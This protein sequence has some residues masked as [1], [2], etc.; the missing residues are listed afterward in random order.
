FMT[1]LAGWAA[2]LGRLSG[3]SDLVIGTP[4]ANRNRPEVQPMI[5]FFVNTLALRV[6]LHDNPTV[7]QLL[8][9][10]KARA[11][12][13]QAH[14]DL[15][16][17]QVVEIAKPPRS[18]AHAPLFQVVFNWQSA[19]DAGL[20]LPGL[21]A[22]VL[23]AAHTT[24]QFDLSLNLIEADGRVTGALEYATALFDRS[25]MERHLAG[26]QVLLAAMAA[27]ERQPVD[28]LDVLPPAERHRLLVEWT[29]TETDYPSESCIHE[30][31]E[32]RAASTPHAIAL[33]CAD[34][35]MSYA[36]L[37]R[38]ANRLAHHLRGLGVRPD[39][40]VAI[41]LNR[42]FEMV[43]GLLATLKAGGAY[44]PL[45]PAY[46]SERLAWMIED[47]VPVAVLACGDL[48][49]ETRTVLAGSGVPVVDLVEDRA[50]WSRRS[51]ANPSRR[52]VGLRPTHLA[53]VIY[54]SGS[55]GRPKGVL[56]E[57][58]SLVNHTVWQ[59]RQFGLDATDV[60]LQRASI[61]FDGSVWELWTTLSIGAR[62]VLLAPGAEKDPAEIVR[63][64]E[65]EGA[66]VV[67][68]V[69]SLLRLMV[70]PAQPGPRLACKYIM[71]GGE[72]LDPALAEEANRLARRGVV[73][74]YGPT[75][76]TIQVL[77]WTHPGKTPA[78]VPLGRP[79]A[80]SRIYV[81]DSHLQPV[82]IGVA[83][84]VY[85]GGV[86]VS[87]GYLNRPQLT[88]ERYLPDPFSAEPGA[89]MYKSGDLARWLP[90]GNVEFLGRN[91]HQVKVRGFRIELGEIESRL[92][93]HPGVREATVLARE[94]EPGDKRLAAY[95]AGTDLDAE[96]L[97]TH[98]SQSL[99]DYM[100]PAAYVVL[101][102]LPLTPNGKVDRKALPAPDAR[103][104]GQRG[105]EAPQ[106]EV[107][108]ALAHI[109]SELLQI[110]RVGR[111][112]DFFELG[113]HSLL[114]VKVISRMREEGLGVDIGVLFATPTLSALAA[115]VGG[116]RGTIVVPSNGIPLG[117][118]TIT[119]DMLPLAQLQ[120]SDIERIVAGVPG[121]AANVQ[122]IYPLAPLQEGILFHHLME[123]EG[124]VYVMP[125]LLAFDTRARLDR[126]VATL[127]AVIDRHDILRTAIAWEGLAE[128]VQV[129]WRSAPMA[130]EEV[131]LDV[132]DGDIGGQLRERYSP[133]HHRLDIRQA[134]LIRAAA[135]HDPAHGRWTLLLLFHHLVVDHTTQDV[136]MQE[137]QAHLIGEQDRLAR[138]LPFRD[139][140]AQAR[141]G[142]PREAHEAFFREM[143]AGVDAPTLPF[144]LA[145]A[146]GDSATITEWHQLLDEELARRLRERARVLGVSAAS[147]CHV[148]WAQVL[149]RVSGRDDVV[150]G[151]VL[152]GR[153]QG[154]QG[155]ER[156]VGLLINTLP[157]RVRVGDD[158]VQEAVRRTHALLGRLMQHE[159]AS[160]ALAQRCS[161]VAAPTPLFT[162]LLNYRHHASA[163]TVHEAHAWEG[164]EYLAGEDRTNYPLGLSVDDL[165]EGFS[166]KAQ[167]SAPVDPKLVC[168]LMVGALGSLVQ[169][170]EHRPQAPLA[171]L[172]VLPAAERDR[173][174]D[175]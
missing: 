91:D 100:V 135:A 43:I 105:Y 134:P 127:Q 60:V 141:F 124:D 72:A 26:F 116:A 17:E 37:N 161:G 71:C 128:P 112:D 94:D 48:G 111:H 64:V 106:G 93:E 54:T 25:T 108:E 107:E 132:A 19:S 172:E 175:G 95:V 76:T 131:A 62:L 173:L 70:D 174:L 99:P 16:F 35:Q 149:A 90:D 55:T 129:V 65:R 2:L 171:S 86:C 138:P 6:Q 104:Y 57:H 30:L 157:L 11:L 84:E 151:S 145:E 140:I 122:D 163:E 74:L 130:I 87:R 67:Q 79:I 97:R 24:A 29:A 148:A 143:L 144:G 125:T 119:P 121:G 3:Q 15:P 66:T 28:R 13:A 102:A 77:S 46:P 114:A 61:S 45:D 123:A 69:P 56:V 42:S 146:R 153:M 164:M 49:D 51:P 80:N 22:Q 139:F 109:W 18:T 126:F 40:R 169:A 103:A 137:I 136:L 50:T 32:A 7:A 165:G 12:A 73:N 58:R 4:V 154:G 118:E 33:T 53:Y 41:C 115:A 113:G 147:L 120:P 81:L 162:A 21:E 27:D 78:V 89:R 150:F 110:E 92:M 8:A 168:A 47:S 9:Q 36:E 101:D 5:G 31:F 68:F 75:E 117:A 159:H 158:E 133:R 83:G 44:V 1:L 14:Q 23:G 10:V 155:T 167:V 152:F 38:R 34:E 39:A 88:A 85:I 96:V 82:P 142:V 59:W 63:T 20:V 170:L 166:L 52:L 156:A 160:L 98:L